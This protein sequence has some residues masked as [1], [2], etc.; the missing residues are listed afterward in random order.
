MMP[1]AQM[2]ALLRALIAFDR[3]AKNHSAVMPA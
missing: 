1:F 3:L 2:E